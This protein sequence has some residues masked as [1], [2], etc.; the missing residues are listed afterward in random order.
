MELKRKR[1]KK[2]KKRWVGC[3][4]G[5]KTNKSVDHQK[6]RKNLDWWQRAQKNRL[7]SRRE[8]NQFDMEKRDY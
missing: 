1:T 3:G 6:E 2:K 4:G 7:K 5:P 8:L